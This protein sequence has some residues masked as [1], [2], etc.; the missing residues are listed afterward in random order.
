MPTYKLSEE[1][2]QDLIR[3]HQYGTKTFGEPQADMY[4]DGFFDHFDLIANNPLSFPE[5]NFIRQGYRRATYGSDS[6]YYRITDNV[7]I[8]AIVGRQ[9]LE[10]IV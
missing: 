5:V 2:K 10:G 9:D 8:M 3:I 6:I 1:A 7:E 4:F